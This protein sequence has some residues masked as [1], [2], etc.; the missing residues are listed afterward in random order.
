M[1]MTLIIII[2]IIVA[3]VLT[4]NL[5]IWIH[6]TFGAK[7][8]FINKE[9][10]EASPNYKEGKFKN[11]ELTKM[12]TSDGSMFETFKKF[13]TG[14]EYD[15]PEKALETIPFNKELFTNPDSGITYSWLGH[16]TVLLNINGKMKVDSEK[17]EDYILDGYDNLIATDIE[18]ISPF[19]FLVTGGITGGFQSFRAS[20]QYQY[21][22]SN[23]LNKLNEKDL[24]NTDF[25]GNS[26]TIILALVVYF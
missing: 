21:G 16:T 23:M 19:N 3:I 5:F 7:A 12:M 13:I 8:K 11:L 17:F 25:K 15:K 6:P 22:V 14:V 26:T 24:E 18:D 10:L 20:V 1:K 2:S 4:I 9:R